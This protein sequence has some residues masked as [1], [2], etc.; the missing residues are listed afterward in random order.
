MNS[1]RIA[2]VYN[3]RMISKKLERASPTEFISIDFIGSF[4]LKQLW[5]SSL[6][7][8]KQTPGSCKSSENARLQGA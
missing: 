6:T 3:R 4:P 2:D 1:V 7:E 5:E 8:M